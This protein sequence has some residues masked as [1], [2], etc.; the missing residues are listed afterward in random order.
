[1][2]ATCR[3]SPFFQQYSD[4]SKHPGGSIWATDVPTWITAV[5]T[6]GLL[7]GAIF[8]AMYAI[9]AFGKQSEQLAEQREI[10]EEQT[11]VLKLQATELD[12]SIKE[13]KRESA[14]RRRAQANQVFVSAEPYE[15]EGEPISVIEV[16]VKN[17]SQQPIYDL[18]LLWPD[19]TGEWIDI[20]D[21]VS[22]RVLLPGKEHKW[23]TSTEPSIPI[24]RLLM[25]PHVIR[26][27]ITFRDA[28][29]VHWRLDSDGQLD[30]ESVTE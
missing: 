5:A 1:M 17:T 23:G 29:R 4:V 13:R 6:V 14:E 15:Q 12:E 28:A 19:E 24:Q 10:N 9:K 25:D 11:K 16:S 3:F 27:A 18:N 2:P 7:I 8:T 21:P 22:L 30:E 20:G 26:A